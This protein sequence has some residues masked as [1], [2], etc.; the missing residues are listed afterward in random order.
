MSSGTARTVKTLRARSNAAHCPS[1]ILVAVACAWVD[2]GR[3]QAQEVGVEGRVD[4]RRPVAAVP[5]T[6]DHRTTADVAGID[7]IVRISS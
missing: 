6:I 2:V 3:G 7:E 1:V 5:A 4:R